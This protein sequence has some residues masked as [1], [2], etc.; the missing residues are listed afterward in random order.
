VPSLPTHREL[1]ADRLLRLVD[2]LRHRRPVTADRGQRGPQGTRQL[3]DV[4][5]TLSA[6]VPKTSL[7]RRPTPGRRLATFGQPVAELQ[8]SGHALGVTVNDLL[9]AAVAGGLRDLLAGRGETLPGLV[10]RATVPAATDAAQ[11]VMGMLVVDL[12][13]GEPDV[14]RRLALVHRATTA[15][16]ARLRAAAGSVADIPVPLPL[17]RLG[18]RWGRRFGSRS[19]SLSITDVAGPPT[20]LWLAGA[21]MREAVPIAPL[22]PQVPLA[23]AALSYAGQLT[24]SID[25]DASFTDLSV[26]AD[27]TAR[28][29]TELAELARQRP[30]FDPALRV[31][32]PRT[33]GGSH[34]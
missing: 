30:T 5:T 3:R 11:Q 1:V 26:L 4:L 17:A 13:V 6:P 28:A 14:L 8:S 2:A 18:V 32:L 25:A 19:I 16:K 10:V 23:V 22:V 34:E 21:R 29:F 12:P 9:L 33:A 24:V 15:G 20:P 7:R 27:G 31:F